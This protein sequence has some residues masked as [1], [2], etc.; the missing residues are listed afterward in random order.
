MINH[1][2]RKSICDALYKILI[3]NNAQNPDNEIKTEIYTIILDKLDGSDIEVN[4]YFLIL[5]SKV[6]IFA[7]Y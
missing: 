2:N 3:N 6:K 1:L 4:Y 7:I 5:H